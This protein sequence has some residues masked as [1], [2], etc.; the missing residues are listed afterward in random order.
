MRD[1]LVSLFGLLAC[2]FALCACQ[3][4]Q[5]AQSQP[6]DVASN[7]LFHD[8]LRNLYVS[9]GPL[10]EGAVG[11]Q[12][13]QLMDRGD[14]DNMVVAIINQPLHQTASWTNLRRHIHYQV[15][16]TLVDWSGQ[17]YYC[18]QYQVTVIMPGAVKRGQ[19]RLCRIRKNSWQI[20]PLQMY[21]LVG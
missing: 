10:V 18:R 2:C 15:T 7:L 6:V 14:H 16:P 12:I 3:P 11:S 17:G 8:Q 19:G 4:T 9:R 1:R 21:N 13:D 5:N 20:I